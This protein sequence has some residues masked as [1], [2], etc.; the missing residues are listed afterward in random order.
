LAKAS[1]ALEIAVSIMD[2]AVSDRHMK[3]EELKGSLWRTLFI[4]SPA[5]KQ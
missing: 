3:S 2:E 1:D 5:K 4:I